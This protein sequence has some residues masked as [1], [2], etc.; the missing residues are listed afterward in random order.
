MHG[1]F[2][3]QDWPRLQ[4]GLDEL[5]PAEASYAL[6]RLADVDGVED[7]LAEAV[8]AVPH[9]APARTALAMR[10]IV[11]G[12][13]IRTGASSEHVSRAQFD[14][15]RARIVEAEQILIGVCADEPDYAPAWAARVLTARALEVGVSE[16]HRRFSRLAR[17]SPHDYP[18]QAQMLQYLSK[19]W[20]GSHDQAHSFALAQAEAA[21][22]GS[23]SGALVAMHHLERWMETGG[24]KPGLT[25]LAQPTVQ[26][27]LA[28]AARRSVLHEDFSL[29]PIG[30]EAHSAFALA[31]WL[32]ERN[33]QAAVHLRALGGRASEFPWNYAM[34]DAAQ[35]GEVRAQVLGADAREDV[36]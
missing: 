36:A 20:F 7:F 5:S 34:R 11:L 15:F 35:L 12:W 13:A 6:T 26:R 17:L 2:L 23:A 27:E 25:Y 14:D 33:D 9:S 1:A 29:S 22:P 21:P 24:S 19:K 8:R 31:F 10:I 32:S 3:D 18:G 28:E 16:A 30:V 4:R